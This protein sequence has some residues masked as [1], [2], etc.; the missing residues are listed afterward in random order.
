MLP[1]P[2]IATLPGWADSSSP[3]YELH[4]WGTFTSVFGSDG[5]LLSGLDGTFDLGQGTGPAGQHL[6]PLTIEGDDRHPVLRSHQAELVRQLPQDPVAIRRS[7]LAVP[8]PK[9][10]ERIGHKF[11]H[12]RVVG[13]AEQHRR[14]WRDE[15]KQDERQKRHHEQEG[16]DA[17]AAH[18]AR[19]GAGVLAAQPCFRSSALVPCG[20]CHRVIGGA[21][22]GSGPRRLSYCRSHSLNFSPS[23]SP[24]SAQKMPS[25]FTPLSR[26][27]VG[28]SCLTSSGRSACADLRVGP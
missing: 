11:G 24:K 13:A 12:R 4:E 6:D 28:R 16:P 9:R 2:W 20:V 21:A 18:L 19:G 17:A 8:A 15:G 1:A 10:I 14:D 5:T 27:A 7:F 23:D 3:D 25:A 26:C 22:R